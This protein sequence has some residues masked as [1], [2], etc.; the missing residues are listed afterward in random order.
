M[1]AA[2]EVYELGLRSGGGSVLGE[3]GRR[4]RLP[5]PQWSAAPDRADR[6]LLARCAGP[7]LDIG[8]GPGR[9]TAAL[10]ARGVPAL[11]I[12]I[13]AL[14]VA[15]TV[16][17]GGVALLRDVFDR[18]PGDGRW[19]HVLLADGNVGI[20]GDPARLLLRCAHLLA[21]GGTALVDVAPPGTGLVA[22]RV[23]LEAAGRRGP[24]FVWSRLDAE[25]LHALAAPLGLTMTS[26]YHINSRWQAELRKH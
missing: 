10:A 8:C 12:D 15:M 16:A 22:R 1:S 14:A 19:R 24:W 25:S 23:R 21:P 3:D 4:T 13:S 9:L 2:L 11:G 18:A 5:V 7:T 6:A 26:H 20:G 17:R